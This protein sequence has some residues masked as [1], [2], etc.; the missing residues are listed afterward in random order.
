MADEFN[1]FFVSVGQTMVENIKSL[2]NKFNIET[3]NN[4]NF[5]PREYPETNQFW[6]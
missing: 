1:K 5:I 6:L 2:A 4:G 3:E